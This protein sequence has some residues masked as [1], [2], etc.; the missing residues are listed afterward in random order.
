MLI[1]MFPELQVVAE[2]GSRLVANYYIISFYR[3]FFRFKF[4]GEGTGGDD[5]AG[6]KYATEIH[7]YITNVNYK[8]H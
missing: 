6:Q 5:A 2:L 4:P 8:I 1:A 7:T 3:F